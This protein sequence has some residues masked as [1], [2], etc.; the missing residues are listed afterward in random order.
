VKAEEKKAA[1]YFAQVAEA[2][3]AA[4]QKP[5]ASPFPDALSD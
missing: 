2:A 5:L 4:K 1:R 3:R